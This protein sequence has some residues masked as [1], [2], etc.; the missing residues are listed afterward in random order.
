MVRN[1]SRQ[2]SDMQEGCDITTSPIYGWHMQT[3][4]MHTH[5]D[6]QTTLPTPYNSYASFPLDVPQHH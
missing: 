1:V 2:N 5:R 6:P 4:N 3:Y